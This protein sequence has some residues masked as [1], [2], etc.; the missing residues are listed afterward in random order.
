MKSVRMLNSLFHESFCANYIIL[1]FFED[2]DDSELRVGRDF[3]QI[4]VGVMLVVHT[5]TNMLQT[6]GHNEVIDIEKEI[7]GGNLV[8]D[9]L[10][11]C[12]SWGLVFDD[13]LRL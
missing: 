3:L 6:V 12:Y 9:A 1:P 11:E 13:H 2:E 10:R 8:E 5:A 7:V 4:S